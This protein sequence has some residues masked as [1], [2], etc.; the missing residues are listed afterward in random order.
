MKELD[1]KG[2]QLNEKKSKRLASKTHNEKA[3]CRVKI[4][5]VENA[6]EE[7]V[8]SSVHRAVVISG[9]QA[10]PNFKHPSKKR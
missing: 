7:G 5:G 6:S 10:L 3:A 2:G 8:K 4:G 1:K 9:R